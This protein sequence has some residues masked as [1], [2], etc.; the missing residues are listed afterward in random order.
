MY[1][2]NKN[3]GIFFVFVL[4]FCAFFS[5]ISFCQNVWAQEKETLF[6]NSNF[7]NLYQTYDLSSEK[8]FCLQHK[9]NVIVE[10][11]GTGV[12]EYTST[13]NFVF[14]KV[15]A[16][17]NLEE[18]SEGYGFVL[19]DLV[20]K[21]I[22]QIETIPNYNA[23]TIDNAKVYFKTDNAYDESDITLNNG[24]RVYLS[25]GYKRKAEFCAVCF[26]F[27]NQILYGF[28]KTYQIKPDGINPLLITCITLIF[29]VLTISLSLILI[30]KKKTK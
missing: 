20:S 26:E 11:D 6:V 2:K 14:F 27:E 5:N 9:D 23:K 18:K 3:L 22:P 10:A 29:A 19:A 7:A 25:E 24:T 12:V 16:Y 13:D 15:L 1:M 8:V 28:V 21:S 30:K 4:I 17:N